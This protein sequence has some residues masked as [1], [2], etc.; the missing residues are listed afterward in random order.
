[1]QTQAMVLRTVGLPTP[2][3]D[4]APLQLETVSLADPAHDEVLVR[5]LAAGLCHSDLSVV[6]GDRPRPTPMALGHEASVEVVTSQASEWKP[7]DRAVLTFVPSCGHCRPCQEGRPALCEAGALSNTAGTL[8]GGE[9]RLTDSNNADVNHHLGCSAFAEHAVVSARSLV[10]IPADL[11]PSIAALFGCAVLTGVGAVV[12]TAA[13]RPGQSVAVIG[14]GGVGLA[15][16]LGAIAAG[17]AHV[18]AVDLS[19][20][21]L[22]LAES[23]VAT[24]VVQAGPDAAEEIR[25]LSQGGVDVAIEAA[26]AV[27]AFDTAYRCTRR[28]GTTVSAGLANPSATW[29]MPLTQLVAE[30][31][32]LKGCYLGGS[33]PSRDIPRFID[34]YRAGRLPVDRLLDSTIALGDLNIALDQLAAGKAV[35]Q[36]VVP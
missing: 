20:D 11:E 28:G 5:V 10:R 18:I 32:T 4:S 30:E 36:V 21:K 2:Y 35:R 13:V 22:A 29:P 9:R 23:L 31:R 33:V 34:L 15:A 26:G 12:N 1:M 24:A 19:A 14:L 16:V 8:L 27:A 25:D 17:A 6:N 7:G 3:A